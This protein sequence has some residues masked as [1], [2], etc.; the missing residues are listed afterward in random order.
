MAH[1]F[2]AYSRTSQT[3]KE[4]KGCGRLCCRELTK[5]PRALRWPGTGFLDARQV[6]PGAQQWSEG[7]R[8]KDR[9][10]LFAIWRMAW[11]G[12]MVRRDSRL[13]GIKSGSAG[14]SPALPVVCWE[15]RLGE[16]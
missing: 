12:P 11:A 4:R 14:K 1:Q 7:E 13:A 15:L 8:Q 3:N 5:T 16:H 10:L 6:F 9:S 2:C